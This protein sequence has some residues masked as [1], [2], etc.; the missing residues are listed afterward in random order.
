MRKSW[1]RIIHNN[2]VIQYDRIIHYSNRTIYPRTACGSKLKNLPNKLDDALFQIDWNGIHVCFEKD[3][4]KVINSLS[5]I[6]TFTD[7]RPCQKCLKS[8]YYQKMAPRHMLLEIA[9]LGLKD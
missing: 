2:R 7:Y 8:K 5:S 6:K 9:E 3:I 1:N 4:Q